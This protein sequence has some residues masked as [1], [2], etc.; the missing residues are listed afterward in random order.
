MI[1]LTERQQEAVRALAEMV[2]SY[3]GLP[4]AEDIEELLTSHIMKIKIL[5]GLNAR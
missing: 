5:I 4:F 3:R 2:N 1:K